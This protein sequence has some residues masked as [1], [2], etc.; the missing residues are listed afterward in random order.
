MLRT[1][2]ASVPVLEEFEKSSVFC[3][4]LNVL[5]EKLQGQ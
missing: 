4:F 2:V 3:C 1:A 5:L